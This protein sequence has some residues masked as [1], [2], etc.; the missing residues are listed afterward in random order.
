MDKI[1]Q[2]KWLGRGNGPKGSRKCAKESFK[3]NRLGFKIAWRELFSRVLVQ[4]R[5]RKHFKDVR[6]HGI[7]LALVH[8]NNCSV[9]K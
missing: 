7:M 3:R 6:S 1:A 4:R 9:T 5:E 2:K 8:L